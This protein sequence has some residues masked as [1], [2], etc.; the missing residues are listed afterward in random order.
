[1]SVV[2]YDASGIDP[3]SG[4][5]QLA[6]TTCWPFDALRQGPLRYVLHATLVNGPAVVTALG[7]DAA[8]RHGSGMTIQNVLF[9]ISDT[10]GSVLRCAA[11]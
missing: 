8:S 4:G 9:G 6:P 11:S 3:R 1:M 5:Y 7:N 2:R 10:N